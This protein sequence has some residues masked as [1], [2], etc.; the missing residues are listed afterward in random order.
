MRVT[1]IVVV[2][3]FML[4]FSVA[5]GQNVYDVIVAGRTIGSLKVFDEKGADGDT[6]THRIES[7]FKVMFYK[8]SYSTQTNYVQGKLVSATC[9][10]HVNGDLKEKTLTKSSTKTLYEVL[11]SGE[12]GED[13]PS[14]VVNKPISS[15][16]TSLYYKEPINITEVYSERYGKMCH[17]R[18][19][20][21]GKY[22]VTLPDGKEGV[23]S[24]KNGLCREVKTDL[25]GFKLRIVLSEGKNALR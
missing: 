18:K 21:E 13:K 7:D 25:A 24:Y 11:F 19:L 12:D 1:G 10:H 5:K 20:S 3:L 4:V 23:Y 6:E 16:I 17:I 15:T 14:T 9:A 8:G 2:G 22:G